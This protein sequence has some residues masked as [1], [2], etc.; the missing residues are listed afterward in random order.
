[1]GMY[2]YTNTDTNICKLTEFSLA[3]ISFISINNDNYNINLLNDLLQ[4]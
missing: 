2:A 4:Y 1:M 3:F